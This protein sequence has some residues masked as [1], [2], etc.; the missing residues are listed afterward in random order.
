MEILLPVG[1]MIGG[2]LFKPQARTDNAGKP[3]IGADGQPETAFN[4]GVA[5]PKQGEQSWAQTAWGQQIYQVGAAAYPNM[6]Q[7]PSFAWK[8]IDG[9][10]QIP[11]KKGRKPCEQEG[12]PGH[13]ILWFSQSWSPKLCNANGTQEL[14]EPDAIVPGYFVQVFASVKGNAPSPTPGV[15]LNPMAVA[16]AG[17]GQ[18]IETSSVD[19]TGVGFGQGPAPV[20][21]L[22]TPPAGMTVPPPA[23]PTGLPG[24]TPPPMPAAIPPVQ[25][26]PG[27]VNG[28]PAGIAPPPAPAP[29]GPVML[30]AANGVTYEA[31]RAAGWTDEQLRSAGYMA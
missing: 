10:S 6:V 3:K 28:P 26:V 9:D 4:F 27:F 24:M 12:Y 11:N 18:R 2:S 30:P 25:P 5:I 15:Y 8:I 7:N 31:Y 21:M 13:W 23:V 22:A 1:R 16:L 29:T 19:T 20:G 17:Y 14:T